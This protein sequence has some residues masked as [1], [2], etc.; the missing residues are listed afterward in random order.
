[1]PGQVRPDK[2]AAQIAYELLNTPKDMQQYNQ[3]PPSAKKI[4]EWFIDSSSAQ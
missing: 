1:M 3:K 4:K 2:K